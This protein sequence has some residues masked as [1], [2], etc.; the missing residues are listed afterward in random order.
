MNTMKKILGLLLS[1]MLILSLT[2]CLEEPSSN[3]ESS[4]TSKSS[5]ITSPKSESGDAD[6]SDLESSELESTEDESDNTGASETDSE[7]FSYSWEDGGLWGDS[8]SEIDLPI[9]KG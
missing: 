1:I 2:A 4:Q 8:D 7:D 6:G 3:K 5:A 9:I